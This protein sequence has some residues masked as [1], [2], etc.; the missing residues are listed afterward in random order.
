MARGSWAHRGR[1]YV[2]RA[3]RQVTRL[4]RF[5]WL[6]SALFALGTLVL[7]G[8]LLGFLRGRGPWLKG[9]D[10]VTLSVGLLAGGVVWWQGHLL[11]RQIELQAVIDLYKEW[12]LGSMPKKRSA[13]WSAA[14]TP[15]PNTV[16][17]VLEF[18]EEVS[19]LE[20]EGFVSHGLIWDTFGWY[21]WR[22]FFYCE[23]LINEL[24][25]NWTPGMP[26]PTLYQ[27]LEGFYH[28]LL[29]M[30]VEERNDRMGDEGGQL[31]EDDVKRELEET[32]T[33]F[34]ESERR[35]GNR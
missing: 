9:S 2:W 19:A 26:D 3:R 24:R 1:Q 21:V 34:V 17:D 5:Y 25:K 22:Y 23:N 29:R 15:D 27:D 8:S 4:P 14:N 11:R 18:L 6:F 7:L 13:A 30:E 12:N 10:L 20:K 28:K 32:R 35:L 31:T 16:E 33:K